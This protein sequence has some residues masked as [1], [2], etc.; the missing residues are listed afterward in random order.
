ML[1]EQLMS[2]LFRDNYLE[3]CPVARMGNSTDEQ[4]CLQWNDFQQCIKTTFAG[5]REESDFMDV[6]LFCEGGEQVLA[7]KVVLSSCSLTFKQLLR[8]NPSKHPVIVL[9]D[10]LPLDL[11]CLL[12]FM[13]QGQVNV[14][15]DNLKSFLALAE[16]LKVRGLCHDD[17]TNSPVG[18]PRKDD[19]TTKNLDRLSRPDP[20]HSQD[21][22]DSTEDRKGDS[23]SVLSAE[24]DAEQD[25]LPTPEVKM[26]DGVADFLKFP[27]YN[28]GGNYEEDF[29]FLE[30]GGASHTMQG[31]KPRVRKSS[32]RTVFSKEQLSRLESEYQITK[33]LSA[34]ERVKIAEDLGL[35]ETQVQIWFQNRRKCRS[36][37]QPSL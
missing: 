33:Y 26:E 5:L 10:V 24:G 13:Y 28:D 17:Q 31:T 16:R 34:N 32:S 2:Q 15:Q 21:D 35:N 1:V 18:I 20:N 9:W 4:F 29:A 12:D 14:K 3:P 27:D 30:G 25:L 23:L 11:G 36:R 19:L 37:K 8:N 7:H 6:T 22:R